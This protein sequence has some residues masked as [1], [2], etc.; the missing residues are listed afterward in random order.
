MPRVI[1]REM[2]LSERL[3]FPDPHHAADGLVAVGGDFQPERLLLAYRSGIFPWTDDPIS[4]WSPDPRGIIELDHFHISRSLEKFLRKNPYRITVDAAFRAVMA[5]CAEPSESR[6]KTWVTTKFIEA[7]CRLHE[8]G[9]AHSVECW[10]ND[11][12]VG[13]I[14][15]VSVGGLFAGESMFHRADNASKVALVA[16]VERL[17]VRGFELFDLQMVTETTRRFGAVAIS[18]ADYLRR[19]AGATGKSCQF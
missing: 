15:G 6:G 17:R 5:G 10:R 7:Y 1:S 14:Y 3:E 4:W 8:L 12:L 16:L 2:V 19:L 9:H 13:G 18:R 11:E